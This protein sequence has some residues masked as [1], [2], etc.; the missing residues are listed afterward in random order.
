MLNGVE[1]WGRRII[2]IH[3]HILPGV[4]DGAD[5]MEESVEMAKLA[6]Q[7]QI[8]EVIATPHYKLGKNNIDGD[9]IKKLCVDL[10]RLLS[11]QG[12][13]FQI[14][15]GNE[16]M[17]FQGVVEAL[18]SGKVLT[19]AGSRY[20]LIEFL[21]HT[22]RKEFYQAV[23]N[24]S[25]AG[26][27][28]VIAHAERYECTRQ[29]AFC[30]EL[31]EAGAYIQVNYCSIQKPFYCMERYYSRRL[32]KS[33]MVHFLGTDMHGIQRRAPTIKKAYGWM[34]K[35]FGIRYSRKLFLDNPQFILENKI[36]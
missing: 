22:A 28:P 10:K 11:D 16:I 27:L 32:I 17:Y 1:T 21:P 9:T 23:R 15:P 19:L 8:T 35:T 34:M 24:L 2:D 3:S 20:V 12:I 14:Y 36:L 31:M 33:D 25:T 4:D 30:R 26:Y 5:N 13:L 7:N 29:A 18:N 6:L